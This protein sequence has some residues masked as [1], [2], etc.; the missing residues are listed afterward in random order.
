MINFRYIF[1]FLIIVLNLN[2]KSLEKVSIQLDWLH[3]FQFAGYYIAKE[4]GFYKEEGLDVDI[5]EFNFDVDLVNDLLKGQS[6]YAVG[7][8]SLI[9]DRLQNK[10]I[11]LLAAIYQDSPMILLSL[12]NSNILTPKNLKDKKV[13]LT[14]DA[15]SAAAINSMIISQGIKLNQI[16]FIPHSFKLED[17]INGKTDAMGCYISNEPYILKQKGID[18]N[19]LNPSDFGFDFYGGIFFT[20]EKELNQY[21]LRVKKMYKATLR[22]WQYAFKN[23][24]ETA[25]LIYNNFNTQN[26]SLESLIYEGEILKKLS[27]IEQGLLGNL[28]QNKLEEIK[29]L[30]LLLGVSKNYQNLNINDIIYNPL[31][32]NFTSEEKKY[33]ENTNIKLYTNTN[34]PPFTMKDISGLK[35]IEIDYWKIINKKLK[36]EPLFE[37]ENNNK[38]LTKKIKE[39][40]NS[41]KF[42]FANYDLNEKVQTTDTITKINIAIATLNDKPFISNPQELEG[43]NVGIS[44]FASYYQSL[45]NKYPNIN[46]IEVK[47]L[48]ENLNYLSKGK[49]YA[50]IDKLPALSY[51]ITQ[52]S[53]TNIKI[54]GTIGE[55]SNIK[56]LVN[57]DNKLLLNILN[58]V[59]TSIS[60]D[61][62]SA[63]NNKYYSVIYQTSIDYSWIYKVVIPLI[64][65]IL[66]IIITNRRLKI[67][68]KKRKTIE[69]EL[70][71]IVDTDGLT[72]IYNRRKIESLIN[73]EIKRSNK[74]SN[75]LSIIFFDIDDF[76]KINDKFGH[77]I[78][79]KI[80]INLSKVVSNSIRKNDY[81][82]R[83]GGEEFVIILP[84]TTIIKAEEIADKI[85]NTIY[86]YNFEIDKNISC[87]FGV[88][89]FQSNDDE[90]SIITRVDNAMYEVKK[91]GK[92]SVKVV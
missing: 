84:N 23:I 57:N 36:K 40:K 7:K 81:F 26:K 38:I 54:S 90:D 64:V 43:K 13:M 87:S 79:D 51:N 60:Q 66:I 8:S 45:K 77:K 49:I 82:G 31:K 33:L 53:L 92:N 3:Q 11:I 89:Q 42:A 25:N 74:Y 73:L 24:N 14:S 12:K 18:Y 56:L 63:I 72:N 58:K 32:I 16:N 62:I 68:I 15:I 83:W 75:D 55:P 78:G 22:G 52:N 19:I 46:F 44:K 9:I 88:T 70:H 21:P 65:I 28:N 4:K 41:V 27:K 47:N 61:D 59:I 10:K 20:S 2:G 39:N 67:E 29:R 69:E 37:I 34:F 71:K 48:K 30:F 35:G 1:L 85:K 80:L 17:L 6:N 76:K 86:T 50:S 5:K 91:D